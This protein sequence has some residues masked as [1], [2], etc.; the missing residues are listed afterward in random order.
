MT[1]KPTPPP[2]KWNNENHEINKDIIEERGDYGRAQVPFLKKDYKIIYKTVHPFIGDISRRDAKEVLTNPAIIQLLISL[3][4]AKFKELE[5][6]SLDG[7]EAFKK[8]F[9]VWLEYW[10]DKDYLPE[11]IA[12]LKKYGVL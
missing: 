4:I 8:E 3:L 5:M 9:I 6:R 7:P 10:V 12:V 1:R 2:D 11:V